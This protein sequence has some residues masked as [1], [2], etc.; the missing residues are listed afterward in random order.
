MTEAKP[1]CQESLALFRHLDDRLG[2]AHTLENL[3][4]TCTGNDRDQAVHYFQ[5]SLR[6]FRTM[7]CIEESRRL[8]S[9]L[10]QM[11]R[12]ESN[13][14]LSRHFLAEALEL[15]DMGYSATTDIYLMNNLAESASLAGDYEQAER[16][17]SRS[18][19][20]V[21][22]SGSKQDLAWICGGLAENGWH[23]GDYQTGLLY[24][25]RSLRLFRELD[26]DMGLTIVLHHLGLLWLA[27]DNLA[28]ASVCLLE[29][30]ERCQ[31]M[32]H[33]LIVAR[34]LAA[35]GALASLRQDFTQTVRLL[36]VVAPHFAQH[37]LELTPADLAFYRRLQEEAHAQLGDTAFDQAW[38][39]GCR[40]SLEHASVLALVD[41]SSKYS[42]ADPR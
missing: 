33:T 6:I 34:C 28:R 27:L 42:R 41:A 30:L 21:S 25:E 4:W 23:R 40:L 11:A 9:T 26:D 29:S 3:A 7:D 20:S 15:A 32:A 39:A 31:S 13:I 36:S 2:E 1:L 5:E 37:H 16:L 22:N 10:A 18:L 35:L 24:G 12:E 14:S 38:A 19:A 17:L 8:L